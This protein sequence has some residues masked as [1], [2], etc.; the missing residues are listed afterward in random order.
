MS[1][2]NSKAQAWESLESTFAGRAARLHIPTKGTFELTP[3]CNFSCKMCYVHIPSSKMSE[4][5]KKELSASEWLGIAKDAVNNGTLNLLITGGEPL[6]RDDFAEIYTEIAQMGFIICVNTNASLVDEK[7]Y[8]LFSKYPPS[9]FSVTLY[10]ADRETYQKITGSADNFDKTIKG[11]EYLSKVSSYLEIKATF[12]KDNKDQLD[13]IREL[14]NR[15]TKQFAINYL[16]FK[17]NPGVA[18]QAA[19]CRLTVSESLDIDI[20]NRLYYEKLYIETMGKT[21][22]KATDASS[23]AKAKDDPKNKD[24]GIDAY[25]EVLTCLAAKAA[26]WVSWD[27]RMLPCGTFD[28]LYTEPLKEGFKEAWD[29]LPTLFRDIK[30]PQKCIECKYYQKCP[31]CPAYF[32]VETG[33][34]D[35]VSDYI[36]ELAHERNKRYA[37]NWRENDIKHINRERGL[38]L[39][40]E[41]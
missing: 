24:Y 26:Y 34:Y 8:K 38:R 17:P 25:P 10:G 14:A 5:I 35:E 15:Y 36:C 11:L 22:E 41:V 12:V 23:Q 16:V 4:C 21:D 6:I 19:E 9:V 3:R 30:H 1:E 39:G 7:Y 13:R 31:N 27:G 29:R 2:Q 18:S 37:G 40:K 32:F 28:Q 33:S 20:S